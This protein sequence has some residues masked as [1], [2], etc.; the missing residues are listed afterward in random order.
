MGCHPKILEL[1]GL[2]HHS[3][4]GGVARNVF[5][6]PEKRLVR[7]QSWARMTFQIWAHEHEEVWTF[8]ASSVD[9]SLGWE[10]C[11]A[12]R[13]GTMRLLVER[14]SQLDPSVMLTENCL[15]CGKRLTGPVSLGRCLCPECY[16]RSSLTVP[17]R[18]QRPL[19]GDA[20]E[21]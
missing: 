8:R 9:V 5:N 18:D 6:V 14:L 16:G 13:D 20:I 2:T 19:P 12:I 11:L 17:S 4:S 3:F 21:G 10:K 1:D 15:V 7:D